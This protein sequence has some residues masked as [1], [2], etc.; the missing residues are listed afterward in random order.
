LARIESNH[1]GSKRSWTGIGSRL[2]MGAHRDRS[3]APSAGRRATLSASCSK[4]PRD[5][6]TMACSPLTCMRSSRR[7][8]KSLDWAPPKSVCSVTKP[9]SAFLLSLDTFLR[10]PAGEA[11]AKTRRSLRGSGDSSNDA[12]TVRNPW[13]SR[14]A[15]LAQLIPS[16]LGICPPPDFCW[17][18]NSCASFRKNVRGSERPSCGTGNYRLPPS[19][20]AWRLASWSMTS[21]ATAK[22]GALAA[23]LRHAGGS[24]SPIARDSRRA[25]PAR[26]RREGAGN[27]SESS[28]RRQSASSRCCE[29]LVAPTINPRGRECSSSCISAMTI[30]SS[31]PTSRGLPRRFPSAS[32]SSKTSTQGVSSVYAKIWRK[33]VAVWPKYAPMIASKRTTKTGRPI[34][35]PR[36]SAVRLLPQPG[37]PWKRSFARGASPRSRRRLRCFH[38]ATTFSSWSRKPGP[39]STLASFT[40]SVAR[41]NASGKLVALL[42]APDIG[43]LPLLLVRS[44]SLRSRAAPRWPRRS[45]SRQMRAAIATAESRSP[46]LKARKR[47]ARSLDLGIAARRNTTIRHCKSYLVRAR[48]RPEGNGRRRVEVSGSQK[49]N[50]RPGDTPGRSVASRT[51]PAPREPR[52]TQVRQGAGPAPG[53]LHPTKFRCRAPRGGTAWRAAGTSAPTRRLLPLQAPGV[54]P[55]GPSEAPRQGSGPALDHELFVGVE[56]DRIA[57]SSVQVAEEAPPA[58]SVKAKGPPRQATPRFRSIRGQ[59]RNEAPQTVA[60]LPALA[61]LSTPQRKE[62][63]AKWP[64]PSQKR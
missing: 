29:R 53:R 34:S 38:S 51:G 49:R 50:T 30:R 48:P 26:I 13:L 41:F 1:S 4:S 63:N 3:R 52:P 31:S 44:A 9:P 18:L 2:E 23:S 19:L 33:R 58:W 56:L 35:A 21:L 39:M 32:S 7:R 45:S 64:R 60:I 47:S 17:W 12:I 62:V 61:S 11:K 5:P 43:T 25:N 40:P 42:T 8:S 28:N 59:G 10:A 15:F 16:Y 54:N 37:G 46:V 20:R 36:A 55:P 6:C 22:L 24:A 14:D 57:A 27:E